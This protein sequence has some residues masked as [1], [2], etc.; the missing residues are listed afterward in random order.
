LLP[1]AVTG[2]PVGAGVALIA[3]ESEGL[4][5]GPGIPVKPIPRLRAVTRTIRVGGFVGADGP[6]VFSESLGSA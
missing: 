2:E 4:F 5:G 6:A 1:V 3:L